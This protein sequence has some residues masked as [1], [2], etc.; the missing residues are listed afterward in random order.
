MNT[1]FFYLELF[2]STS[3]AFVCFLVLLGLLQQLR[4]YPPAANI[5]AIFL[6]FLYG[7][8]L[9]S[10]FLLTGSHSALA[11]LY[12]L[13]GLL[14][15][16]GPLLLQFSSAV[17]SGSEQPIF[18]RSFSILG[19][20]SLVA[21]MPALYAHFFPQIFADEDGVPLWVVVYNIGF[22]AFFLAVNMYS[23]LRARLLIR[24]SG[25][26]Q[27]HL[28]D[29]EWL[30]AL[31]WI[32]VLLLSRYTLEIFTDGVLDYETPWIDAV[33]TLLDLF[34]LTVGLMKTFAYA[35]SK[36]RLMVSLIDT[37]VQS[38]DDSSESDVERE[39]FVADA[40][41][42]TA[43][44]YQKSGL[45]Q[46]HAEAI[47]EKLDQCMRND[48]PY[49]DPGLN[50][51]GLAGLLSVQPEYLSQALNQI[52]Q[53]NFYELVAAYRVDAAK[54]LIAESPEKVLIDVAFE[55]GFQAKSSFNRTFKKFTGLT[56]SQYKLSISKSAA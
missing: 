31:W 54:R 7:S 45:T 38:R 46:K 40:V 29:V 9:Y 37:Q 19:L 2:S 35:I 41:P 27:L 18:S 24:D 50:L 25:M 36:H 33:Y 26:E 52:R 17:I 6:I 32:T 12:I 55:S 49:L 34:F 22:V 56:P 20:L 53:A 3:G 51:E 1:A 4:W 11:G 28:P 48:R 30:L 15:L 21:M 13:Q 47:L 39:E 5:T 16:V 10:L 8:S 44:K 43:D 14:V 23:C 42:E